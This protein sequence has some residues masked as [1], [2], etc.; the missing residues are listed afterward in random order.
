VDIIAG[1]DRTGG[2]R[3]TAF[4]GSDLSE[5]FR[6]ESNAAAAGGVFVG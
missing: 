4:N 2:G 6:F 5:R 3:L 1:A